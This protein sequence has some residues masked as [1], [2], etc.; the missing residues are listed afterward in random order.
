MCKTPVLPEDRQRSAQRHRQRRRLRRPESPR[1]QSDDPD[2]DI[3]LAE[4]AQFVRSLF[5][6]DLENE[7]EHNLEDNIVGTA[8]IANLDSIG[9]QSD[10]E[11]GRVRVVTPPRSPTV[12]EE[13]VQMRA[14]YDDS[15]ER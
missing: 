5:A 1:S 13:Q 3:S 10:E 8:I 9:D 7:S 15:I 12:N 11:Q 2:Q 14:E 6:G 4:E